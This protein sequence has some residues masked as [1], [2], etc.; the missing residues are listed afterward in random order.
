VIKTGKVLYTPENLDSYLKYS[1]LMFPP[2]GPSSAWKAQVIEVAG[3]AKE[4][5]E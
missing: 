3:K 4:C 5:Q 1:L 2:S